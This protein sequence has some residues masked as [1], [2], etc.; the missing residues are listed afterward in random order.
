LEVVCDVYLDS[1][2]NTFHMKVTLN[3]PLSSLQEK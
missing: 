3:T 2:E 1:D